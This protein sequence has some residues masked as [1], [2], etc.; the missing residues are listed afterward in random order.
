MKS[1]VVCVSRTAGS[2]GELVGRMVADRLGYRFVDDEV[3]QVAAE[4]AGVEP[5]V[6][7]AEEQRKG[8]I[9]RILDALVAVPPQDPYVLLPQVGGLAYYGPTVA[10]A[11]PP[12]QELREL[13]AEAVREIAARGN[14]VIVAHAASLALAGTLGVLRILVTASENTRAA[15]LGLFKEKDPETAVRESDRARRDYLQRF[16]G[17]KEELPTHYDL[18]LNT[19]VLR[20]EQAA[21][22]IVA[23]VQS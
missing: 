17:V 13:I 21:G 12:S 9:S 5:S 11:T 23:A 15:R 3:I 7:A 20:P 1:T 19:D 14:V 18:V 16:Y 10:E 4:K 6:V 2:G 22:L 8:I